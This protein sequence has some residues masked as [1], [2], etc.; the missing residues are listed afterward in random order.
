M[1]TLPWHHVVVTWAWQDGSPCGTVKNLLNL[2]DD[3]CPIGIK[4]CKAVDKIYEH[5]E[6]PESCQSS[7]RSVFHLP[8]G[9]HEFRSVAC[10]RL[11][12]LPSC[13][14]LWITVHNIFHSEIETAVGA[15]GLDMLD[16]RSWTSFRIFQALSDSITLA[17][18]AILK[19]AVADGDVELE[20]CCREAH[21]KSA[22]PLLLGLFSHGSW[23]GLLSQ[24]NTQPVLFPMYCISTW[25]VDRHS[26]PRAPTFP[27]CWRRL[28]D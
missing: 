14:K 17:V 10:M 21:K 13:V 24:E 27:W 4:I 8:C 9:G 28:D 16:L 6:N 12:L 11:I 26:Q 5:L 3:S 25:Y 19:E 1:D 7:D 2:E 18:L 15:S 20:A 22:D 23:L